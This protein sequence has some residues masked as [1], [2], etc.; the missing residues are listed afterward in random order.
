MGQKRTGRDVAPYIWFIKRV[1]TYSKPER[2]V[3]LFRI[4]WARKGGP[5]ARDMRGWSSKLSFNL[6]PRL[7]AYY[8]DSSDMYLTV[9]GIQLHKQKHFGGWIS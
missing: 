9:F 2:K 5:G 3:R 7:F 4:V 8:R 1:M 6:V